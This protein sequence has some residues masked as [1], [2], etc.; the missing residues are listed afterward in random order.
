MIVKKATTHTSA[1]KTTTKKKSKAN[2]ASSKY[3]GG[4][5]DQILAGL[6][7]CESLGILVVSRRHALAFTKYQNLNSHGFADAM[8]ELKREGMIEYVS[9]DT[10]GLTDKGRSA[11]PS[12]APPKSNAEVISHLQDIVNMVCAAS[13]PKTPLIFQ[14][15]SDGKEHSTEA[16]LK[17]TGYKH[18]NSKG[19]SEVLA[20]LS[21]LGFVERSNGTVKLADCAFPLGRPGSS[22]DK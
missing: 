18:K 10:V 21:D 4:P 14:L 19:F 17:A 9:G 12:V 20:T 2:G 8:I 13:G 22:G 15:L 7:D 5:K 16:V 1:K 11:T 3:A 6:A